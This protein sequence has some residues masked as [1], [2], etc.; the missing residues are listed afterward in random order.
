[1]ISLLRTLQSPPRSTKL[2]LTDMKKSEC[3]ARLTVSKSQGCGSLQINYLSTALLSI[4]LLPRL[5]QA[6]AKGTNPRVVIVASEV[7]FWSNFAEDEVLLSSPNILEKF[8]DREYCTKY[9]IY[10]RALILVLMHCFSRK[11]MSARYHDTKR[12]FCLSRM[13]VKKT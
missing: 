8:S 7:H 5:Q 12:K 11:V 3:L 13:F 10:F 6:A 4:L 1:M 9:P 2:L